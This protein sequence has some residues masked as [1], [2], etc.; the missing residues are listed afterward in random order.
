MLLPE[1]NRFLVPTRPP[2]T[3]AVIRYG[4]PGFMGG[5]RGVVTV[6]HP[7][8][9]RTCVRVASWSTVTDQ[10]NSARSSLASEI[11]WTKGSMVAAATGESRHTTRAN[12]ALIRTF[13]RWK[14]MVIAIIAKGNHHGGTA[15]I[16]TNY[17]G[18]N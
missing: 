16:M 18:S 12:A 7:Q 4:C 17:I 11:D 8:S 2:R 13:L 5:G 15:I 10:D 6:R 14:N 1:K 9:L 3:E